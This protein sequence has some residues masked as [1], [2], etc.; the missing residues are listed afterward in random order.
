MILGT[1]G[2]ID[3]GK[4]ALV[5]ALTGVDTDRLPEEKRRGITIDLGFAP[6]V[7]DDGTTVG[8]VDVPG[9]EAFVR[10]MLAG[11]TG[12]DLAL[13]VVAA[14]EG[15]MPQTREHLAI[16]GLLGVRSG[17]V[18]LTKKDLVEPEWL[19]LVRDDVAE[20]LAPTPLSDASVVAVSATTGDGI[21]ELRAAIA[22][23]AA[24]VPARSESDLFRLPVDR[25]F[26]VKGTGTVITG[27]VWTG[28]LEREATVRIFPGDRSARVRGLQAHGRAVD[29]VGPG[30]RAAVALAGV[31]LTD[32]ER[33]A[34]L[35]AGDGWRET[36]VL[37]ATV[38][39]LE[40]IDEETDPRRAYRLHLATQSADARIVAAPGARI[41]PG[42]PASVRIH[43]AQP[44]IARGGDRFVLRRPSPAGTVGGGEVTDPFPVGSRPRVW[45]DDASD[46]MSRLRHALDEAG[47]RGVAIAELPV[48]LGIRP[49]DVAAAIAAA[50]AVRHED[51]AYAAGLESGMADELAALVSGY[52]DAHPLEPGA[53]LQDIRSRIG[54][55]GALVDRVLRQ[56]VADQRLEVVGSLV[57]P[58]GWAPK[59]SGR[60]REALSMIREKLRSAGREP[61]AAPEL[62]ASLGGAV[63]SL[64]RLLEREGEV[65]QVEPDRYYA[66][67][68]IDRLFEELRTRMEPGRN[69]GPGE[70]RDLVGVSRK[71]LI[72]LLE[73]CDRRGVTRRTESGR[74]LGT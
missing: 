16:L 20:M 15:I 22:R 6:L 46:A 35:V 51:R 13:L 48:R 45:G 7:L 50:G 40:G 34:V 30:V 57:R 39:F 70:L 72:P 59:L 9:H 65:V 8:V 21:A 1:A 74:Q 61:P 44:I 11:A 66:A 2:H 43:L 36:R 33:G 58:A 31:D 68:A 67:D 47:S 28:T 32:V 25:A 17:V 42:H 23:A 69:Y 55:G 56:C 38:T 41:M 19:S 29:R 4:T 37:R 64:L 14:D 49:G 54:A 73:F 5:R 71:Y 27:T 10:T 24:R 26:T 62:E 63:P 18:A 3:H 52:L 53:P 12:I 60:D